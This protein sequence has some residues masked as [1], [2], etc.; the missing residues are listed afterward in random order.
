MTKFER[1]IQ[2]ILQMVINMK[3]MSKKLLNTVIVLAKKSV[4]DDINSTSSPWTYQPQIPH[5]AEMYKKK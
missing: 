4:K 3:K 5:S 2:K 1:A